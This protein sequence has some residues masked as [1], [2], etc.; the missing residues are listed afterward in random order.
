M[1]PP[2]AA[3]ALGFPPFTVADLVRELDL[4]HQ[5][6]G[7]AFVEGAGG[8]RS[9]FTADGDNV[10]LARAI[11]ARL[12]ILVA[13]AG[14]GTINAVRLSVDAFTG[15]DTVVILN[16]YEE[17]DDLHV[18]NA[19]WLVDAGYQ[20]LTSVDALAVAVEERLP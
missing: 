1:A 11:G 18:R 7:S 19:D 10:D 12:A 20:V 6:T 9:P 13:D 14:L 5:G 8:P 15:F 17:T 3:D 4:D 2:R 16:R